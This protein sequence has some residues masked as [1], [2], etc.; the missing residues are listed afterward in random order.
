MKLATTTGDF[1]RYVKSYQERIDCVCEA[2]FKYIDLSMYEVAENDELLISDN[3]SE[4]AK[5]ILDNTQKRG[6]E[7]VQAHGP[8]GNPL[9]EDS[10]VFDELVRATIRSI[11]VCG[12]LGIP[13]IVVHGGFLGGISKEEYFERNKKFF[14]MLFP[15]MERN[16][17]NVLCENSTH[18]NLADIYFTNSGADIKE[19][20]DYVDH[21]LFHACWDTG[22]GNCEGNQY[23]DILAIGSDLYAV[24]INDNSGRGDEHVLPYFGTV[25]MDEIMNALI[26]INYKGIFT[27]ECDAPL[28]PAKCWQGD[29]RFFERDK[30][31][32][33]PQLFMQKQV[34]K[35]LYDMGEYILKAYD[36]YEK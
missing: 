5:V 12:V 34:E 22:H 23:D 15:A 28:R 6:A 31:L 3:W 16:N 29:R 19:F 2:G 33:E 7:F 30:R 26:D 11:D 36:C 35:L 32:S 27:F 18:K 25:N 8:G 4:N 24:H 21:P 20:V 9:T 13:N 1:N 10:A 14:E 17:V